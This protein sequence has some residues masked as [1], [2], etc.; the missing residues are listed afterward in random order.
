[1]I[2]GR[3]PPVTRTLLWINFGA[4]LFVHFL[5][6]TSGDGSGPALLG[7]FGLVPAAFWQGAAWQP[8][9]SMF[10]HAPGLLHILGNMLGLWSLGSMLERGIGSSRYLWLYMVSGLTG[11]LLVVLADPAST[12]AT[13]GA[14]GA[15]LGLLGAVAVLNPEARMLF[16]IF[17]MR[18][19]TAALIIGVASVLFQSTGGLDI[20]S[21]LGHLGGLIGGYLYTRF[22]LLSERG[23]QQQ[24]DG[25]ADGYGGFGTN[26]FG[27]SQRGGPFGGGPGGG[28][29]PFGSAGAAGGP[30]SAQQQQVLRMMEA[31]LRN[32]A[33][34]GR[35]GP[36]PSAGRPG[37]G[38]GEKV[39]NPRPDDPQ[40][41]SDA[42]AGS[43]AGTGPQQPGPNRPGA[44][45]MVVF[46]PVT[47]RFVIRDV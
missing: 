35:Q 20:I 32:A 21:H 11:A 10:L 7:I 1:M 25:F 41:G 40:G 3:T 6:P 44:N 4:H 34:S 42:G 16:F 19:R 45:R 36:R 37:P 2:F 43:D 39:I 17:P 12:R 18:A 33:E 27:G 14:S 8:I 46:D 24:S 13:I 38:G 47:G 30:G 23:R 26:P 31:M 28:A 15:V 29:S 9:T 5:A 22:A